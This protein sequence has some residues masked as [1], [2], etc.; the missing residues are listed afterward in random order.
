MTPAAAE[1]HIRTWTGIVSALC[2]A[3]LV[4]LNGWAL[5]RLVD[6]GERLGRVEERMSTGPLYTHQ[7]ARR[8]S[9]VILKMLESQG[10]IIEDHEGRLRIIERGGMR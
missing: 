1:T 10:K 8:D 3:I 9:G 4:P 6:H 7:D 2:L 5:S